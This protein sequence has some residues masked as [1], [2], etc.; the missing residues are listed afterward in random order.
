M[1][2]NLTISTLAFDF[3]FS[4]SAGSKRINIS[5]GANLPDILTIRHQPYIDSKTKLSGTRS[6][7]R[8]ERHLLLSTG[9]IAP[10]HCTV[11]V[12][13]PAD[14][15]VTSSDYDAVVAQMVNLLHGTTNTGGLDLKNEIFVGK[16]Q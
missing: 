6:A 1:D 12:A 4:E 11:V 2:N 5:R 14:T 16:Q 8:I 3:G 7:V 13:G 10:L 9:T 15:G